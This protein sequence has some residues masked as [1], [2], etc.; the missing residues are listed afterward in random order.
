[1]LAEIIERPEEGVREECKNNVL[2]PGQIGRTIDDF[3]VGDRAE[4]IR[5]S[6]PGQR[7]R[8]SRAYRYAAV[9]RIS[10]EWYISS[11]ILV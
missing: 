8:P 6:C 3:R 11:A 2:S 7:R 4:V 9:T 10:E 1:M 5:P